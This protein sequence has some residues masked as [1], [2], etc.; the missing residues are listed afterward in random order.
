MGNCNIQYN[1]QELSFLWI[2]GH[3]TP[4]TKLPIRG[5]IPDGGN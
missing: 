2:K 5:S 3:T 4:P 1:Y